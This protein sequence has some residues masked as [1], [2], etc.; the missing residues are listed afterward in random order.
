MRSAQAPRLAVLALLFNAF[1]WGVSWWPF[2]WL[3]AH[4]LASLWATSIIFGIG[5][6]AM[7]AWGWRNSEPSAVSAGD[8]LGLLA[9]ALATGA[10]NASFNWAVT[11]GDVLRVVL[12]FYLMPIWAV[13]L[14]RW[15]LNEPITRSALI[16]IGL[17]LGGALIVLWRPEIGMPWPRSWPDILAIVGGMAFAATNVLLRRLNGIS[18]GLRARTMFGG[19]WICVSL[20]AL[21]ASQS[22][23][24]NWPAASVSAWLPGALLMAL[25]FIAANLSLQ[26]GAARLSANVTAVIMLS[27][28]LF[29]SVSA[30][31]FGHETLTLQL[32]AG[33][34]LIVIAAALAARE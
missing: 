17:A 24:M 8:R 30:L 6:V 22:G 20:V 16:R 34:L 27:E 13:L 28:V 15:L 9:L 2:R 19:A 12:L 4:G 25:V 7:L 14:A 11:A 1:T 18:S 3:E 21:L 29:A 32:T 26:Y 33:G 23:L 10:T 5:F 31:L